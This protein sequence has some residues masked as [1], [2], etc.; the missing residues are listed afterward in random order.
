MLEAM[1]AARSAALQWGHGDEAVEELGSQILIQ[2]YDLLQWGH[3]DEAVE[4]PRGG[5]IRTVAPESFN[6]ATAMKPWKRR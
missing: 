5:G 3:G 2:Y 6:G 1:S 4:E